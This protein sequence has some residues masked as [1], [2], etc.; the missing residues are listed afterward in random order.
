M[1]ELNIRVG[2]SIRNNRQA[3]ARQVMQSYAKKN[4]LK[5][6]QELSFYNGI[7]FNLSFLAESITFSSNSLYC[8]NVEWAKN[9]FAKHDIP[10]KDALALQ[11]IISDVIRDNLPAE[12]SELA[13]GYI[14]DGISVMKDPAGSVPA[15]IN[16]KDR[17]YRE[18]RQYLD[19]LLNQD[20]S[21]ASSFIIGLVENGTSIRDIYTHIFEPVQIE[22]GRLWQKGDIT[23]AREH[24]A[25]SVTQLIMSQ[26]YNYLFR[27]DKSENAFVGACSSGELHEIGLRMVSDIIE[28]EGWDTYYLGAN[29]PV[30]GIVDTLV[31]CGAK[32]IGLSATMAFNLYGLKKIIDAVR[33]TRECSQVKILVGGYVF[34]NNKGLWK[35]IGA[36]YFASGISDAV[37]IITGSG[38]KY[39]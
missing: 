11:D 22:L 23:V 7:L 24:Y 16:K 15:F 4:P 17:L 14:E 13:A 37:S 6:E 29:T 36:D 9:L 20:K 2:D 39:D 5:R 30:E 19:Y 3:L 18:S 26:L 28:L 33:S 10:V 34:K 27:A 25:T 21:S 31:K 1:E 32:V 12:I 8:N 35:E 38:D